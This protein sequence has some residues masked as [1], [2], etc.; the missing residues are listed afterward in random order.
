[1]KKLKISILATDDATR[2]KGLMHTAS[3]PEDECALF[4]FPRIGSHAF[5]NKNVPYDIDLG[6]FDERSKLVS[7]ATLQAGQEQAVYGNSKSKYVVEVNKGWFD[8]NGVEFG[9][10]LWDIVDIPKIH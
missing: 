8:Q 3:L 9:T 10:S 2:E 7:I 5:W 4:V 6:F 1:M